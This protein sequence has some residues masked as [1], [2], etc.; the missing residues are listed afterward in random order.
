VP[1]KKLI[2]LSDAIDRYLPDDSS[3]VMGASLESVIPF[4]AGHEIIRQ[5]RKNLTLIGPISDILFDQL[6]GAGCVRKV[7]AAWVGNVI[8]GSGYNFRRA[9]ESGRLETEDHTNLTISLALRAAAMGV[10]YMPTR[11]VL[12]SDLLKTNPGLTPAACPFTGEPVAA[13]RAVQPDAAIIHVQRSD[14]YG[15]AHAWGNPGITREACLAARRIILTAEEI[16]DTDVITSDPNRVVAPGFRV[17]AVVHAPWGA[18]PSPVPGHY[19]RDHQ[20]FLDYRDASR[21]PD[22]FAEWKSR[23]VDGVRS[24]ADYTGLLGPERMT[25]LAIKHHVYSERV[26]Y[27]C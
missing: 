3:V 1:E 19:N 12:G 22:G 4:A 24:S 20:A 5:D 9:V 13:V 18:H 25:R 26:D 8:T 16:V 10:P 14:V 15:N 11:S 23:W 27:G 7:R 21:T 17:S 2:S 6:I